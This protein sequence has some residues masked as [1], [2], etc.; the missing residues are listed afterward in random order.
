MKTFT[1]SDLNR[2]PGEI[3]DFALIEPV[4]MTKR[5]KDKIVIM[6]TDEYEKLRARYA[7]SGI[8]LPSTNRT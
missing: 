3:L 7:F 6:N 1:H 5:G 8:E 2:T 4:M